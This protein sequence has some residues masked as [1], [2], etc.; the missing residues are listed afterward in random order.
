[1]R[2]LLVF[3]HRDRQ[4]PRPLLRTMVG[5][6]LRRTRLEQRRTL[7][8]VA[9]SARISMQ[10]LSELERGR[11]EASSEIL[12]ALCAALRL[13]LSELLAAIARDL[14]DQRMPRSR[15]VRLEAFRDGDQRSRANGAALDAPGLP[16]DEPGLGVPGRPT[17]GPATIGPATDS[18]ATDSRA[19]DGRA[20][21]GRASA[22][23]R[24]SGDAVCRLAA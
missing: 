15:V 9:S 3:G 5:D 10:Y 12:A 20:T 19:T 6:V 1:M 23:V 13:D 17:D 14:L 11:K 4:Q 22:P 18:R 7:V 24:R 8:D 21:D 16:A 2:D